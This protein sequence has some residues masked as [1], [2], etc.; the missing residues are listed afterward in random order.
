MHTS[1]A[2]RQSLLPVSCLAFQTTVH[3]NPNLTNIAVGYSLEGQIYI[4]VVKSNLCF[5]QKVAFWNM[6]YLRILNYNDN[7]FKLQNSFSLQKLQSRYWKRIK[8]FLLK[9]DYPV[10]QCGNPTGLEFNKSSPMIED[11]SEKSDKDGS[12]ASYPRR[13]L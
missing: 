11:N 3:R 6:T 5:H 7:S 13:C 12:F 8:S 4:I 1:P 10:L 9:S 2:Q